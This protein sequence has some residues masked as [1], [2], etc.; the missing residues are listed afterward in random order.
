LRIVIPGGSGQIGGILARHFHGQGHEVVVVARH[1]ANTP[2]RSTVWNGRD[3]GDWAREVDGAEVVVNLAGRSVNCRYNP[4]N[5]SGILESRVDATRAVGHAVAAAARPPRIW[6]NASTATIYRHSLDRDMDEATGEL[7]GS[8]LGVPDTWRFSI[9]VAKAWEQAFEEAPA[10]VTRKIAL[11]SA[12]VMSPDGGGIFD[13]LRGLVRAGLGGAAGSGRQYVSWIHHADFVRAI[14]LLIARGDLE[15]VINV[16]SPNP[17]PQRDFMRILRQVCG[18]RIGLPATR[19]MLE[20][21]ARILRT[22]TELIL[23]SR[24]VV[25][26]RLLDAGFELQFPFWEAAARDL[27]TNGDRAPA[28]R[29]RVRG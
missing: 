6:I 3:T 16:S 18:V 22:E 14:E 10:P 25:P 29:Q 12:M 11:R 4:A 13:T 28:A 17:L 8:E 15:G 20:I 21:G 27:V 23:K 9:Q 2:W 26:R 24:R 1:P 19:W 5:R 7:G